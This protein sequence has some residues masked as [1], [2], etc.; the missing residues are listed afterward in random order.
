MQIGE[1]RLVFPQH[2]D[3]FGLRFLHLYNHVRCRKEIPRVLHNFSTGGDII[4]IVYSDLMSG[5]SFDD[6]IMAMVGQFV[7][8]G[9][10][11]ADP[12]FMVFNFFGNADPHDVL[13][14]NSVC[15][16]HKTEYVVVMGCN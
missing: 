5:I 16:K 13:L 15:G 7:D 14:Q 12:V 1:K 8:A 6:D 10:C 2:H 4:R 11:H 9:W 3:F